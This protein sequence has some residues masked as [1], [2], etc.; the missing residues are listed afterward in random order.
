MGA[1]SKKSES[2]IKGNIDDL[3]PLEENSNRTNLIEDLL[4]E[5]SQENRKTDKEDQELKKLN[6][7][8]HTLKKDLTTA[9][10]E[11]EIFTDDKITEGEWNT[12][13]QKI[14]TK[15]TPDLL[16]NYRLTSKQALIDYLSPNKKTDKTEES[17]LIQK[18][19]SAPPENIE[20]LIQSLHALKPESVGNIFLELAKVGRLDQLAYFNINLIREAPQIKEIFIEGANTQPEKGLYLY[21]IISEF[22]WAGEVVLIQ[23]KG[24]TPEA[25][26]QVLEANSFSADTTEKLKKAETQMKATRERVKDLIASNLNETEQSESTAAIKTEQEKKT[27]RALQDPSIFEMSKVNLEWAGELLEEASSKIRKEQ[28]EIMENLE[29]GEGTTRKNVSNFFDISFNEKMKKSR[30]NTQAII[31]RNLYFQGKEVNEKSVREEVQRIINTR[32]L[33]EN[34]NIFKDR[35]VVIVAHSEKEAS[36]ERFGKPALI[37]RIK[38]DTPKTTSL[39]RPENKKESLKKTKEKIL[40]TIRNTKQPFTFLFDG[41]GSEDAM[42]LSDGNIKKETEEDKFEETK[43]TEKITITEFFKAY[44]DRQEAFGDDT[45]TPQTKDIFL[46]GGCL[47]ANFIRQFYRL[48]ENAG[49]QKPI[50]AGEAEYGQYAYSEGNSRSNGY[51]NNFYNQIFDGEQ[52]Q[53][54]TLGNLIKNDSK[55]LN[56]NPSFYLPD[57][58][59]R[60]MQLSQGEAINSTHRHTG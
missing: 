37:A 22:P 48:C 31:S 25:I 11:S 33:Y 56:S 29:L 51:E 41:H 23:A 24:S 13:W 17:K 54:A 58:N 21:E 45:K 49:I 34:I 5:N 30:A 16:T 6:N 2:E 60:T 20:P 27:N 15:F 10:F 46:N 3:I 9:I 53:S 4:R 47:S 1:E 50:F 26:Q 12:I 19:I 7:S 44:K 32:E 59:N 40:A 36:E 42:Y 14:T 55:N 28:E 39:L 52:A 43:N 38:K 35:N 8:A 57:A 18:F